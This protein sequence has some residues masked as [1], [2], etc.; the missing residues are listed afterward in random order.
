MD[1]IDL[2]A[3]IHTQKENVFLVAHTLACVANWQDLFIL[4]VGGHVVHYLIVQF[5]KSGAVGTTHVQISLS[6]I[7]AALLLKSGPLKFR[8]SVRYAQLEAN[9]L[10]YNNNG[11]AF[12]IP[13]E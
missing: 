2:R 7:F 4:F 3:T 11:N 6:V 13:R 12:T 9:G 8:L 5:A 1:T 10:L